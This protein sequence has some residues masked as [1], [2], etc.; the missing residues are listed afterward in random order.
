MGRALL[1]RCEGDEVKVD[2]PKGRA[3][4]AINAVRYR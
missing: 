2:R 1:G 3:V 4:F